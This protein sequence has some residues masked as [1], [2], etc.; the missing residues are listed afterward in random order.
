MKLVM[1]M[2]EVSW[3]YKRVMEKII[4][5]GMMNNEN[6]SC[7]MNIDGNMDDILDYVETSDMLKSW[8]SPLP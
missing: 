4:Y 3:H 2:L 1:G 7:T 8:N 5:V 6:E